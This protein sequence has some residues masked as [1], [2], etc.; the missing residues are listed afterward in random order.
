MKRINVLSLLVIVAFVSTLFYAGI[1]NA[2]E[3]EVLIRFSTY[4]P[5]DHVNAKITEEWGKEVEKR[6][7]G[8]VKVRHY[9][10]SVLMSPPQT[11]DSIVGGVVLQADERR[12]RAHVHDIAAASL[13]HERDDLPAAEIDALQIHTDHVIPVL[14]ERRHDR[15]VVRHARAVHEYVHPAELIPH[16]GDHGP[17]LVALG[18]IAAHEEG[19]RGQSPAPCDGELLRHGRP[20]ALIDV[21]HRHPRSLAP[22]ERGHGLADALRAPCDYAELPIELH[23][24]PSRESGHPLLRSVEY[25][26][27]IPSAGSSILV[28]LNPSRNHILL[29]R[30][31]LCHLDQEP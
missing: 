14:L 12:D 24:D 13:E 7:Q 25:N 5:P 3:K 28:Q 27:N 18:H 17:N 16:P 8:K 10:G 9:A 15:R 20:V 30:R 11:W 26:L 1:S 31:I 6:T 23:V 22:E 4:F 21:D 29:S 2:A 19:A